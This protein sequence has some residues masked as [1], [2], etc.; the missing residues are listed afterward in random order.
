MN[1]ERNN[2]ILNNILLVKKLAFIRKKK[3]CGNIG[4]DELISAGN[5]G[6]VK[7]ANKFD[8]SK[9]VKFQSYALS[10]IIGEMND[11]IREL[12]WEL[13]TPIEDNQFYSHHYKEELF[14]MIVEPLTSSERKVMHWY[15][16]DEFDLK[17]IGLKLMVTESRASQIL[18]SCKEKIRR[19]WKGREYEL[20]ALA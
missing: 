3:F 17:Q 6:L 19:F 20:G 11:Y 7:A 5:A 14:E 16:I 2:L 9:G 15:F 10:R 4:I 8:N 18:S 13:H 12:N 1:L